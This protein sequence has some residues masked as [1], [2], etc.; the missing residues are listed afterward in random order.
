MKIDFVISRDV[1]SPATTDTTK[2][3]PIFALTL[4][5][6]AH[7]PAAD[8]GELG[9]QKQDVRKRDAILPLMTPIPNGKNQKRKT[10][11]KS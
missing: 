1:S 3:A 6:C 9:M 2:T 5:L 7:R 10:K 11:Q 4:S 8:T